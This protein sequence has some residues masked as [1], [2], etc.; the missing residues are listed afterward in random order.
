MIDYQT[1]ESPFYEANKRFLETCVANLSSFTFNGWCNAYGYDIEG[2]STFKQIEVFLQLTKHQ[3]TQNGMIV[4]IDA[5]DNTELHIELKGLNTQ[6]KL[7]FG[8]NWFQALL[9]GRQSDSKTE[10]QKELSTFASEFKVDQLT[11]KNGILKLKVSNCEEKPEVL[12]NQ[13]LS[14][15]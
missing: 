2:K 1:V 13:L 7:A 3:T 14:I 6:E 15:F 9:F 11:L 4:P 5:H 12:L 10:I 8:L